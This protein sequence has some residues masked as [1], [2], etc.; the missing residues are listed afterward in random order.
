ML[1]TACTGH[2]K[3]ARLKGNFDHLEQ[4]EFLVYSSDEGLDRLDTLR[5]RDGRFTYSLP[6]PA[7]A[8]LHI[9]YPNQSELVVFASPGEDIL[10]KGDAQNLSEVE[11]SG[12]DDN[13][14]YTQFRLDALGKSAS[15]TRELARTCILE[16]PTLAASRYLFTTYFL[17]DTAASV[18]LTTELYDSLSRACPDDLELSRLASHVRTLGLLSPGKPLPDFSLTLTPGHGGNGN[19][20][21]NIT[22]ADCQGKYLL[23]SFWATW[24][25]GSQSALYRSRRFRREMKGKGREV[26]LISYSL[27]ANETQFRR[28]EQRDSIDYASYCDC[29]CFASPLAQQ[30]GIRNLP[31]FVLA[32]PDGTIL[33][34]GNDWLKHIQP[35]I[36]KL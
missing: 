21:K 8:T 34:S 5:I 28:A 25:S 35:T 30:W 19:E 9:L 15:E 32:A 11:V 12:D 36:R 31:Y 24:K 6:T 7:T 16:H 33:A 1:L 18:A 4:G 3:E 27:D 14:T 10:V 23:I 17:C 26:T 20:L 29:L 13:E 22:K 2:P